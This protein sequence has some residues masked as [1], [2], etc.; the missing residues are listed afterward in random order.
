MYLWAHSPGRRLG[1]C[2]HK[3]RNICEFTLGRRSCKFIHRVGNYPE[4][5]LK[6]E[7]EKVNKR[8]IDTYDW[9]EF[10]PQQEPESAPTQEP[11]CA[12]KPD[13][14]TENRW[15]PYY[16]THFAY[17]ELQS[18]YQDQ[19]SEEQVRAYWEEL[20]PQDAWFDVKGPDED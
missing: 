4:K 17:Q 9:E 2:R 12:P 19:Y 10:S 11:E 3:S 8:G 16:E 1:I 6:T 18:A 15:D 5:H 7:C 20:G 13:D 14:L